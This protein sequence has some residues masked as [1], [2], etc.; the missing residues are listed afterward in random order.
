MQFLSMPSW[1]TRRIHRQP[2]DIEELARAVTET[3]L[4]AMRRLD[5]PE[6]HKLMDAVDDQLALELGEELGRRVSEAVAAR[7]L[8]AL[9]GPHPQH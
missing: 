2:L 6:R 1:Q 3:F 4:G 5:W 9:G 7:L 8:D